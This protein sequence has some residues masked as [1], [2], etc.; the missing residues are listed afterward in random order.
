MG[1]RSAFR[2]TSVKRDLSLLLLALLVGCESVPT[3]PPPPDNKSPEVDYSTW[4]SVTEKPYDVAPPVMVACSPGFSPAPGWDPELA[5]TG[6]GP[7]ADHAINVRV[8]P[9]G[10]GAFRA[11]T[12]VPVGTVVVKEKLT[13][14][15]VVAVGTMTKREPGYDPDHGDW[16]Y[17]YRELRA[18]APPPTTGKIESCVA[19]HRIAAKKDHLFRPYLPHPSK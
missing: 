15:K 10:I 16:E 17:G 13:D 6:R 8:N 4:A 11:R 7:H 9:V 2:E 19:C 14:K 1:A 3:P 12:P 18:D 5:R